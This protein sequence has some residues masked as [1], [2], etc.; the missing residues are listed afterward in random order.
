MVIEVELIYFHIGIGDC[1]NKNAIDVLD[2][3]PKFLGWYLRVVTSIL[4]STIDWSNG[5]TNC[6]DCH[7]CLN[8]H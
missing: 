4:G 5:K 8:F 3:G 7:H 2:M 6:R 1:L